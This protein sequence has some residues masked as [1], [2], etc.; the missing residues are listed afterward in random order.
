M[1]TQYTPQ[2]DESGRDRDDHVAT[3]SHGASQSGRDPT[4]R[5]LAELQALNDEDVGGDMTDQSGRRPKRDREEIWKPTAQR[6]PQAK[7]GRLGS[8]A[9]LGSS[10]LCETSF[11]LSGTFTRITRDKVTGLAVKHKTLKPA[12]K[13]MEMQPKYKDRVSGF[14]EDKYAGEAAPK[15]RV[16]T[17]AGPKNG[18]FYL[19]RDRGFMI[20]RMLSSSSEPGVCAVLREG[21]PVYT[22]FDLDADGGKWGEDFVRN[23]DKEGTVEAVGRFFSRAFR[24][25]CTIGEEK[26]QFPWD[27][28]MWLFGA[29]YA[30]KEST[31]LHSNPNRPPVTE[32]DGVVTVPSTSGREIS[33]IWPDDVTLGNFLRECVIPLIE[34]AMQ[35]DDHPDHQYAARICQMHDV[36]DK[37]TNTST[38]RTAFRHMIDLAPY[39]RTQ[40]FKLPL[41]RKPGKPPMKL[42]RPP[43]AN[44]G[45]GGWN[46][47]PENQIHVGM[48]TA[49]VWRQ[50]WLVQYDRPSSGSSSSHSH[51]HGSSSSSSSS[52]RRNGATSSRSVGKPAGTTVTDPRAFT[53]MSDLVWPNPSHRG[54]LDD[55]TLFPNGTLMFKCAPSTH[56]TMKGSPHRSPGNRNWGHLIF[57]SGNPN[58]MFVTKCYSKNLPECARGL[59]RSIPIHELPV[60]LRPTARDL[61]TGSSKACHTSDAAAAGTRAD[62]VW[63]RGNIVDVDLSSSRPGERTRATPVAGVA[64]VPQSSGGQPEIEGRELQDP[65]RGDDGEDEATQRLEPALAARQEPDGEDGVVSLDIG[66]FDGK[67]PFCWVDFVRLATGQV[68]ANRDAVDRF[69]ESNLPR[70]LAWVSASEGFYLKKDDT[71]R[72]MFNQVAGFRGP[73]NFF[74]QWQGPNPS[75]CN[76]GPKPIHFSKYLAVFQQRLYGGVG[77][78]PDPTVVP[79]AKR[80][81]FNLWPGM[82]AER[83]QVDLSKIQEVL[84]V[85]RQLWCGGKAGTIAYLVSWFRYIV[86]HP[87]EKTKVAILLYST[88]GTGKTFLLDFIG[89]FVLGE[90]LVHTYT[91]LNQFV[92]KHDTN[93]AGKKMLVLSEM[94]ATPSQFRSTFDQVK[95]IIT[96]DWISC[97]PK[98][99]TIM[100][101]ENISNT[102]VT[103]NNKDALFLQKGDRR[104][105]C[106]E[107]STERVGDEHKEWWA[108]MY[109]RNYTQ[110]TGDHFYSWLLDHDEGSLP[111]PNQ[112]FHTELRDHIMGM[113]M[114]SS[115]AFLSK[116]ALGEVYSLLKGASYAPARLYD[117]Y[118]TWCRMGG[119][120]NIQ[121]QRKFCVYATKSEALVK[122]R[123]SHG[124][125]YTAR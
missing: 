48:C 5:S 85:L 28:C 37:K 55:I 44:N 119:E 64:V 39:G 75:R 79:K 32:R 95:P 93:K 33:P 25:H 77:C 121:S 49:Q 60:A 3:H 24:E 117:E 13:V 101:V 51:S 16:V 34:E 122:G 58:A 114:N 45:V 27:E 73:N 9:P 124:I 103:T 84:F 86:A 92:E 108:G 10:P 116:I 2:R 97:N 12:C 22:F 118:A 21:E 67:D 53:A 115:E 125:H 76:P 38:T 98:N 17:C 42:V 107:V 82:V 59:S 19:D 80:G 29:R 14:D 23:C 56:C 71:V 81:F 20:R 46:V 61:T 69:M 41:S 120:K 100:Q 88:P 62:P 112:V 110:E 6:P 36:V 43:R 70:V 7:K 65:G 31:H 89:R 40:K 11:L 102:I 47:S 111:C 109:S 57:R 123:G 105:T 83:V 1:L 4:E 104:Y 96:D 99:G 72:G 113:S 66:T 35:A 15:L 74:V 106:L 91:G 8:S 68:F 63:Q 30:N 90:A 52:S 18:R 54:T 26:C 78:F 50:E 94:A 87:A